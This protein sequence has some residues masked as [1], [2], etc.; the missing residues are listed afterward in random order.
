MVRNETVALFKSQVRLNA[1]FPVFLMTVEDSC[2]SKSSQGCRPRFYHHW[3]HQSFSSEEPWNSLSRPP[4]AL[5]N[6][7]SVLIR[8][9]FRCRCQAIVIVLISRKFE[10]SSPNSIAT[11]EQ[12]I[13]R[14]RQIITRKSVTEAITDILEFGSKIEFGFTDKYC[15][16]VRREV[17]DALDIDRP[18]FLDGRRSKLSERV[19][20]TAASA[21]TSFPGQ[22]PVRT[23][24]DTA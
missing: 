6:P 14:M 9:P 1:N 13:E 21:R 20:S 4:L 19:D 23:P 5:A 10:I 22:V 11:F 18:E 16:Q 24:S 8:H 2:R 17:G 7:C 3:S 12:I 15:P